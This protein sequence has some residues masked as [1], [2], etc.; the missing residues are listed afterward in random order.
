MEIRRSERRAAIRLDEEQAAFDSRL[1]GPPTEA[2]PLPQSGRRPRFV[3]HW[4]IVPFANVALLLAAGCVAG[5]MNALV[6]GGS[7]VS[8]PALVG[9]GFSAF[10]ANVSSSVALYPGG[11]LSAFVYRG[12]PGLVCRIPVSRLMV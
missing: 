4:A 9:A 12:G 10:E 1:G 8:L 3:R 5:A 6:G 11:A 7:F 2:E